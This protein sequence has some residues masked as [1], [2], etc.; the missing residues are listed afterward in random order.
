MRFVKGRTLSEA[1]RAYHKA[2]A[3]G[4]ESDVDLMR[5][6]TAF[7]SVCQAIDYAHSRKI[8]H[9]D[10]KGQNVVLGDFGEVIVLDW[11]LAKQFGDGEADEGDPKG[12]GPAPDFDAATI[13]VAEEDLSTLAFGRTGGASETTGDATIAGAPTAAAPPPPSPADATAPPPEKESGAGPEGT[14]Q[15]QLLGTP[16]YMAPEQA[17]GR[18][19]LVDVRTDV[20][21]LGAILYEILAGQPPFLAKRTAEILRMVIEDAPVPPRSHNPAAPIDLQ[22]VCLKAIAKDRGDRYRTAGE[23]ASD[24][25]RHL[26][27]EP[28]TAYDEPWSRRAARWARKHRT[29]VAAA[30]VLL[31][32]STVAS[33]VGA[34]VVN[35]WRDEAE[36]Q[37]AVARQ[38]VDD[39]YARVGESWLEDR[40]DPLQKEFLEKTVAFYEGR[41]K[42]DDDAPAVRLEHGRM[43]RRMADV[44]AKFGRYEDAE[45]AYLRSLDRLGPLFEAHRGD[46]EARREL[47]STQARFAEALF[48][49]D[50]FDEAAALLDP[51]EDLARPLALPDGSPAD[52]RRLLARLLRTRGQLLR[53][54][55]DLAAARPAYAEAR[56]LLEKARADVPDSPEVRGELARAEDLL[57]RCDREAGDL[58]AAEAASRRGYDL[59]DPLVAEYPTIPRYR[60]AL[61]QACAELGWFAYDASRFDEAE[62]LW[63]RGWREASRL[64]GDY[65]D[66]PEYA[67]DLAAAATNY[68]GVLVDLARVREA[69]PILKKAVE[70]NADLA[71]RSPGD[72]QVR[73]DLAKCHFNLGYLHL[74][75][76][77][78][79]EAVAEI[80]KARDLNATLV[81]ER[82][83]V[84]RHRHFQATYLRRLGEAL[85]AAGR[86]GAEP[87]YLAA[88]ELLAKLTADHPANAAYRLDLARC[89]ASLG[90]QKV[91]AGKLDEAEKA[92]VDAL[93]AL[94]ALA[95]AAPGGPPVQVLR[96]TSVVLSNLGSTRQGAA[97]GGDAEGPIRRALAISEELARR[98]SPADEDVESLAVARS[99]LAEALQARGAADEAAPL[100]AQA[101]E[102]MKGL[103]A[104]A[105]AVPERHFYLGYML[106][107]QAAAAPRPEDART[108]LE[109]AVAHDEQAVELTSGRNPTYRTLLTEAR[110]AL[111]DVDL[112]LAAYDEARR[113]AMEIP[114][115][116]VDHAPGCVAAARL[117]ARM[118]AQARADE[119]LDRPRREALERQ[120]L[121]GAVLLLREALDADPKLDADVKADPA[122]KDLLA[123]AEFQV[124]LGSLAAP[125]AGK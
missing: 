19:D 101:V 85:D 98:E 7:V 6:L 29:A 37:G 71:A 54:K 39:M 77:R 14:L 95:A 76:G 46:K 49:R 91:A 90:N 87:S 110:E 30:T 41:T 114:R 22:A 4:N 83:D 92:F 47:A 81:A 18:H 97:K 31:T 123:H 106:A 15:G 103:V 13:A 64:A 59:L 74:K 100:F 28:V 80:E 69:E 55:G 96:E 65:P 84:P 1:T 35:R 108:P 32:V 89:L 26:A 125:A 124:L 11:G 51:A 93:A 104:K 60:E 3:A 111:A 70:L 12:A 113:V 10:L 117:L 99:T 8:L 94:D 44:Y 16:A 112:K 23:L 72:L 88:L 57:A 118:A 53:R 5:L 33:G 17:Q 34:V 119:K 78:I 75:R 43:L 67:R 68:G 73:F 58:A 102:G 38:T 20:Y 61:C 66:R 48:R 107:G 56:D 62:A 116:A 40:L 45:R 25:Q 120:G 24:V 27:D 86:P 115:E 9:R 109:E 21:G 121:S 52:D 82:P 122:F 50:R 2:R 79:D 42:G 36:A 105:P 63:G